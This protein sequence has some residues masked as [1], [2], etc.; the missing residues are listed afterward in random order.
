MTQVALTDASG[1]A[2][3]QSNPLPMA[4]ANPSA[5]VSFQIKIAVTN[6]AQQLPSNALV[7]GAVVKAKTTNAANGWI[8]SS[9]VNSTDDGT[10][11]GY[12]LLP[13]EAGSF[14]AT[15]SNALWVIG[16][17]NDVYYVIGN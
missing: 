9:T 13:G 1:N 2:I 10:G 5:V 14:A 15:N 4:S 16:T 12:R 11:T 8:G 6:T 7:N 17:A 3:S